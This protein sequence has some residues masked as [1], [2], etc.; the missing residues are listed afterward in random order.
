MIADLLYL[1]RR[2]H[3]GL[4]SAIGLGL[5]IIDEVFAEHGGIG[6]I[7]N[8]RIV[9]HTVV[10]NLHGDQRRDTVNVAYADMV[11]EVTVLNAVTETDEAVAVLLEQLYCVIE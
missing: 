3:C 5:I 4:A 7:F 9:L 2:R 6:G 1:H 8:R 10:R 11:T